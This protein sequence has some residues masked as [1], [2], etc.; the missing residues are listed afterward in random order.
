MDSLIWYGFLAGEFL[1]LTRT[2]GDACG[3]RHAVY[4]DS[5]ARTPK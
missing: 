2:I 3:K 5:P 4:T 1:L